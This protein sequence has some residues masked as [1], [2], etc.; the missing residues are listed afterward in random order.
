MPQDR[1][2]TDIPGLDEILGGGLL[3]QRTYLI[4]GSSGTGKTILSLQW[5]LAGERRGEK[6]LYITLAEPGTDLQRD[7]SDFGWR[8]DDTTLL[9]LTHESEPPGLDW[10]EYSI[11]APSAVERV[12]MWRQIYDAV[13]THRPQRLVIDSATQLRYLSTDEYQFRKNILRLV[14]H[15]SRSGCTS[16]LLF[17][18]TELERETSV[19]LAADGVLRLKN[20]ISPT[21]IIGLRGVQVDKLRG[22]DFMSGLHPMRISGEGIHIW[23]HRIETAGD[24][25]PGDELITSGILELDELLGGG[26]ESGTATILSGP[27]GVGKSTL[28]VQFLTHAAT[29]GKRA[30]LFTFEEAV[31]SVLVRSR[32]MGIPLDA[33]LREGTLKIRRMNAMEQ[34]P[35]EFLSLVREAVEQDGCT[36][37]MI[38]SLRGYHLAMQEYGSPQAHMHNLVTYLDRQ[39]VTS[40]LVSEVEDIVGSLAATNLGVSYLI[41]NLI[42]LRYAEFRGQVNKVISCLKKRIGG[43]QPELRE[44]KIS[45]KGI[46][47][48]KK[49]ENLRGILTGMPAMADEGWHPGAGSPSLTPP[50]TD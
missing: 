6:G 4:V 40:L 23:P 47:V 14:G 11:F 25:A 24:E 27:T 10:N 3:R 39:G 30:V 18:P 1:A 15:L 48:G 20:E 2:P 35:D 12:P 36:V 26:L 34:Y 21:R 42:V 37:V 8:V 49:L 5:L 28:G 22:S 29:H 32:A 46:E 31:G 16:F 38:D 44:L 19:A 43:F 33:P 41:D 13:E 45:A 7:V 17:E 9:D 50:A